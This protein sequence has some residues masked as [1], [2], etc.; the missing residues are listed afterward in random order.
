MSE[1]ADMGNAVLD[2]GGISIL[3]VLHHQKCLLQLPPANI[4]NFNPGTWNKVWFT[5]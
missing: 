5:L 1:D 4:T 2:K 3:D